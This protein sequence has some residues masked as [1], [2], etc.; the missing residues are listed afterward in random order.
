M[1]PVREVF[2]PNMKTTIIKKQVNNNALNAMNLPHLVNTQ[3][4]FDY[5]KNFLNSYLPVVS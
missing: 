1:N 4:N 2:K 3:M 5:Y